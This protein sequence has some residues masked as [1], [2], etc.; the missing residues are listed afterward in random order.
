MTDSELAAPET[1]RADASAAVTDPQT[2][3]PAAV[4]NDLPSKMPS[5]TS[6]VPAA[7]ES[8]DPGSTDRQAAPAVTFASFGLD[9]KILRALTEQ[10]YTIPTPIQAQAIPVVMAGRDVMGAAQTGTGKTAGFSLPILQNLMPLANAS[11][12]PARHP[13]RALMLTPTREL[14]DQVAANVERYAQHTNLRSTVV[15]GGVDMKPQTAALR[16]GVELLIATPGRLL[17]HVQQKTLDLSQV[18][19]LVLDEAD[20]M[21]DM[22]FL[23]DLQR[24]INL[25]PARRQNLLFSATF[26]NEIKKLAQSFQSDPV[27]IEVARRNAT[28]ELVQQI[29][30]AL[31]SDQKRAAV[32]HIIRERGLKQV[33][34]FSNTKIGTGRLA[35]E[36]KN[37]G[38][39][40]DAIHGDKSQKDRMLA[41]DAFKKGEIEVLVATDVAARG[42]DIAELPAVIN[43]D[44]PYA[45]EDYVHRIG[46][47]GRAGA[48]G[49]AISLMAPEEERL[50]V[51]IEK[52]TK[53]TLERLELDGFRPHERARRERDERRPEAPRRE[54]A[55]EAG[56]GQ[57][58][59]ARAPR[60]ASRSHGH[61]EAV[62]D[63]FL[64]PYEPAAEAADAGARPAPTPDSTTTRNPSIKPVRKI[65]ALLG[66]SKKA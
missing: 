14:A 16:A 49:I 61:H 1:I 8:D 12:S 32:A 41:L 65:A 35:R 47:T 10:G 17:D 19:V 9:P 23:P 27:V 51:E 21:L 29:L 44:L 66:G 38:I 63:F 26:S 24:I 50:V 20:R 37:E 3:V 34:V 52:L 18:Q 42:L 33:L 15:F 28:A 57:Q 43:Y 36:L 53:R 6:P 60:F 55:R 4:P 31:P 59:G 2:G 5:S 22:G 45:P 39:N 62:D 7:A 56:A 30:H 13:V 40:A 11:A 46:R 54:R 25:L 64:K 58:A 48:S